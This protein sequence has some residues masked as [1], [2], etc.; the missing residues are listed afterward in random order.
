MLVVG[1]GSVAVSRIKNLIISQA[2]ITVIAPDIEDEIHERFKNGEI[3]AIHERSFKPDDLFMYE[4]NDTSINSNSNSNSYTIKDLEK[5]NNMTKEEL[6]DIA[7]NI[8]ISKFALILVAIDNSNESTKI[9]QLCQIYNLPSNIADI[10]KECDF[11]FGSMIKKGPLQIMISTNG[12]S[13]KY[14][15]KIRKKIENEIDD[16]IGYG[17]EFMGKIRKNLRNHLNDKIQDK[18]LIKNRMKW[19]IT[20]SNN[21]KMENLIE[22][23]KLNDDLQNLIINDIID[24]FPSHGDIISFEFIK[25]KYNF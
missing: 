15:S 7:L 11:Y 17:L 10:P 5:F 2:K 21:F 4:K 6:G 25:N 23:G 14:A 20:I 9:F 18:E 19:I 16:D 22:M 24:C 12:K 3:Y 13:P 8:R 1:G